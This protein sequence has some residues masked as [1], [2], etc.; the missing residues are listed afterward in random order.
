MGNNT[1]LPHSY[2]FFLKSVS[3]WRV[4]SFSFSLFSK[5]TFRWTS[6]DSI[7]S[8][9]HISKMT[10]LPED[11]IASQMVPLNWMWLDC[12]W[13]GFFFRTGK[14]DNSSSQGRHALYNSFCFY[15]CLA[16]SC[17]YVQWTLSLQQDINARWCTNNIKS[18]EFNYSRPKMKCPLLEKVKCTLTVW[19]VAQN[20]TYHC[21]ITV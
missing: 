17:N 9:T 20:Q 18:M 12:I 14:W 1:R 15:R 2:L 4:F 11:K 13:T 16:F 21:S 8:A 7:S 6:D 19:L 3:A 10:F 5:P